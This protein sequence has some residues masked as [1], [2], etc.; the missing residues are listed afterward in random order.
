MGVNVRVDGLFVVAVLGVA[1]AAYVYSQREKIKQVV[2]EDLNPASDQ[3]VVYQGVT[4]AVGA[5]NFSSISD[6]VFGAYYLSPIG[7]LFGSDESVAYAEQVWG[8]D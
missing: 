6:R 8:I 7:R 5:D 3:N 4:N 1:G 2:T